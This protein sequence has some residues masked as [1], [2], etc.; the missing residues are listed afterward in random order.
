M[1]ALRILML[2]W[3]LDGTISHNESNKPDAVYTALPDLSSFHQTA[4]REQLSLGQ[5]GGKLNSSPT[6]NVYGTSATST[7][8]LQITNTEDF[9]MSPT[10][11]EDKSALTMAAAGVTSFIVIL[12]VVVI[13]LVSVVSLKFRCHPCKDEEDKQKPQQLTVSYSCS[14]DAD[15]AADKKNIMLVSMKN[16]NTNN[17]KGITKSMVTHDEQ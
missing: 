11:T 3:I 10:P 14:D 5:H 8:G 6:A 13:V 2:L 16:L 1:T 12:V 15:P 4:G 9:F 7:K 17:S